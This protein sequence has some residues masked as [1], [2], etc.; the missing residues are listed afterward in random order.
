MNFNEN[1]CQYYDSREEYAGVSFDDPSARLRFSAGSWVEKKILA[2]MN[3]SAT[4]GS[5]LDKK[6]V[7]TIDIFEM[8]AK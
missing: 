2:E 5:L 8:L 3:L 6:G 7:F 1:L 4:F